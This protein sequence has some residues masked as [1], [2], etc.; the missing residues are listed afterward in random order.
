MPFIFRY[1]KPLYVSTNNKEKTC[2]TVFLFA[3]LKQY[4]GNASLPYLVKMIHSYQ[5]RVVA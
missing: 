5:Q 2:L 4:D 1:Y 3:N